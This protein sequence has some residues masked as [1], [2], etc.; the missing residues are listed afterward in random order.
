MY[1]DV[2]AAGDYDASGFPG[3]DAALYKLE[4]DKFR[5]HLSAMKA[6]GSKPVTVFDLTSEAARRLPLLITVDD[7]GVSAYTHMADMLE[8]AGWRGHFFITT[9]YIG[10]RTFLNSAQ[11]RE[12]RDRG[13]VIGSHSRS[14]PTRMSHCSWDE[15]VEEWGASVQTLSDILSERVTVAS[16]PGGYYSKKVAAAAASQGIEALF[17]SEPTVRCHRVNGCLVLGRYT[18][19]RRTSAAAVAAIAAGKIAPRLKQMLFWNLKKTVKRAGGKHYVESIKSL[20][21]QE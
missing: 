18:V 17:T 11:I 8:E 15:M 13:H 14:H 7:G 6:V 1:H 16:V 20:L 19:Q 10:S 5:Q 3:A 12:L 21:Y 2:V 9:G 4:L